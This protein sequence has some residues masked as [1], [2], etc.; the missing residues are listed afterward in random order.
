MSGRTPLL[1]TSNIEDFEANKLG[2][3]NI[4]ITLI[5]HAAGVFECNRRLMSVEKC[6]YEI[7][8]TWPRIEVPSR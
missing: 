6:L 2:W 1:S 8:A 7:L 4:A 5:D 3:R